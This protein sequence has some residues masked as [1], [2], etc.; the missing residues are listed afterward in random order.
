[1]EI[2]CIELSD[3]DCCAKSIGRDIFEQTCNLM[4]FWLLQILGRG[5]QNYTARANEC[6]ATFGNSILNVRA[7]SVSK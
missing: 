1:M 5:I 2:E 3:G 4:L 7:S 6:C